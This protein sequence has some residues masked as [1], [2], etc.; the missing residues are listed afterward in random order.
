MIKMDQKTLELLD[1]STEESPAIESELRKHSLRKG[2]LEKV[3]QG[4]TSLQEA[5]RLTL[6]EEAGQ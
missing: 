1:R 5:N 4:V 2:A 3:I 6:I